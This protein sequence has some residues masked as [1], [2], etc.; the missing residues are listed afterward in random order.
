HQGVENVAIDA[1]GF[2]SIGNI[3][4]QNGYIVT[5]TTIIVGDE[6]GDSFSSLDA[7]NFLLFN[8]LTDFNW[9]YLTLRENAN[10]EEFALSLSNI[11]LTA[12]PLPAGVWLFGSAIVGFAGMRRRK[13]QAATLAAA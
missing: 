6:D 12:V 3:T 8:F 13:K 2:E 10:S 7:S 4:I 11:S 9:S 5:E 1:T